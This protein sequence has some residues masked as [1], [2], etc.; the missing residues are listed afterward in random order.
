MPPFGG[1]LMQ[2]V[3]YGSNDFNYS[4]NS[5][6]LNANKNKGRKKY[7]GRNT[8]YKHIHDKKNKNNND[9]SANY[10]KDK[11]RGQTIDE[12][13]GVN[14]NSRYVTNKPSHISS[15]LFGTEYITIKDGLIL[16]NE[17]GYRNFK[18]LFYY[19]LF[20]STICNVSQITSK[21]N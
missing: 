7:S 14:N 12:Y 2:L 19:S 16:K 20:D 13:D 10:G 11:T 4:A 6:C 9:K 5:T 17:R 15:K 21:L 1:G 18:L 8:F 3:A